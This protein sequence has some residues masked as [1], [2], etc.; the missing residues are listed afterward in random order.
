MSPE[1]ITPGLYLRV[2]KI[3]TWDNQ[4]VILEYLSL[5]IYAL[6][7]SINLTIILSAT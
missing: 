7:V 5:G 3:R 4:K 1:I 2:T 6:V